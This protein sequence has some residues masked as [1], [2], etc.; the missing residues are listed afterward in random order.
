VNF[1]DAYFKFITSLE[2][3]ARVVGTSFPAKTVTINVTLRHV[4]NQAVVY[5]TCP[6]E[7]GIVYP[8]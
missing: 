7:A 1:A 5:V 3:A 4:T 2:E 8:S 6:V